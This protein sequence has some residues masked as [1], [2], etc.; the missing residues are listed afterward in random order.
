M[1]HEVATSDLNLT[2]IVNPVRKLFRHVQ[3]FEEKILSVNVDNPQ[4][5]VAHG[6]AQHTHFLEF[7][8]ILFVFSRL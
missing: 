3:F 7:D 2:H 1:L 5:V 4:V 8:H 6:C